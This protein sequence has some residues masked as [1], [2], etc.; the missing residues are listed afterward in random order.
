MTARF[1]KHLHCSLP[2]AT[3]ALA[4]TGV[5]P[6]TWAWRTTPNTQTPAFEHRLTQLQRFLG[7]RIGRDALNGTILIGRNGNPVFRENFGIANWETGRPIDNDTEF[8]LAS[9]SKVFT[10][11]A[12]LQLVEQGK[13]D[14]D[15]P[16]ARYFPAFPYPHMT[17][18]QLLSH[19][20]GLSDQ[21]LAG[22]VEDYQ[23]HIAPQPFMIADLVPAIVDAHRTMKLEPG[24]KWW[25]SNLGF[26]LLAL[27]VEQQSGEPLPDY[28]AAHVFGPA[29]M[30]HSYIKTA[31]RNREDTPNFAQNYAW[32]HPWSQA[33]VRLE[34]SRSYYINTLYGNA[35]IV[36]T[37]A[38]ML[39]FD[40][41]LRNGALLKPATLERAYAP[42]KLASGS[43]DF[44]WINIGGMGD[45]DDAL[46]W[47]RFRD[48]SMGRIVWH[49]GGMPGCQTM[50]MRNLDSGI[51]IIL[52][53]NADSQNLHK[54]ALSAMR[55]L[56]GQPPIDEPVSLVRLYG[57]TLV[58]QGAQAA[59]AMLDRLRVDTAHYRLTEN[60][61]NN[62]G[63]AFREAGRMRDALAAF[64]TQ[65]RLF[66]SSSNAFNS[67]GEALKEAGDL[68][69]AAEAL[70]HSLDLD[71][72]NSDSQAALARVEAAL[73]VS[74]HR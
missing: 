27:L 32:P 19:S 14:L 72:T 55:I 71:S 9:V 47:F 65:I 58:E 8:E 52:L 49:A 39:R 1:R 16:F 12:V 20:A 5:P 42:Q 36:S 50:F 70:R 13:V 24:E 45:A 61:L 73:A 11:T 30:K 25:Y 34:G 38:D 17:I 41:A 4:F 10:A 7:D 68:A 74:R 60:D 21:D 2:L 26:Q 37:A 51:T 35:S 59:T 69:A 56:S 28:L 46:G 18:R 43:P 48:E 3:L 54:T 66:P 23:S 67:Y 64:Q 40:A 31:L 57:A 22:M 62:L 15:A 63:Y 29:G 44:V 53:A 6:I 33:R